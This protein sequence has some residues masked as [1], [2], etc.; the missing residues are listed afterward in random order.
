MQSGLLKIRARVD[1]EYNIQDD[2]DWKSHDWDFTLPATREILSGGDTAQA[3]TA[4]KA[5]HGVSQGT[6]VVK[7]IGRHIVQSLRHIVR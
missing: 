2:R 5:T 7:A 1:M 4:G 6:V 3:I